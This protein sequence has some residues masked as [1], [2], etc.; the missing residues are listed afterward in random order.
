M[1]QTSLLLKI[2]LRD[3]RGEQSWD[4]CRQM[5]IKFVL[6]V[7]LRKLRQCK[8]VSLNAFVAVDN[9]KNHLCELP[10]ENNREIDVDKW[11]LSSCLM[12]LFGAF[13]SA[14]LSLTTEKFSLYLNGK[15]KIGASNHLLLF[16]LLYI[17]FFLNIIIIY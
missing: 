7:F 5:G 13:G 11:A 17:F 2:Y 16:F 3:T 12:W 4:W 10:E 1:Q 15:N 14:N 8:S 6:N 9:L